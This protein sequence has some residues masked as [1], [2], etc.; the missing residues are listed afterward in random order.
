MSLLSAMNTATSA[1]TADQTA[2]TVTGNNIA[3]LGNPDYSREVTGTSPAPDNQIQTGLFVGTGV[4]LTGITRQVDNALNSRLRSSGSDNAAAQTSSNWIGQV[5]STLNALSGSDLSA[6]MSTFFTG[7]SNLANNPTDAGQR[8]V[9]LQNGANIA[10]YVQGLS[11]QLTALQ[12]DVSQELPQQA[13][14]ADALA[15]DIAKLNVQIVTSQGGSGGTA[16]SLLDQRDADLSKLSKLVNISTADQPNGSINVYVGSEPLVE[17]QTSHG[18][19]VKNITS[20]TGAQI[21]TLVFT[22]SGGTVPAI[23]GTLGASK[24]FNPRSRR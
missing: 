18:L 5:Q 14:S 9:V 21:P 4:D 7:W 17:G 16:N 24:A 1:I 10:S 11:G 19:S 15:T 8:Q 2:I 23:S 6:Q 13:K 3:N 12:T 22:D 20:N